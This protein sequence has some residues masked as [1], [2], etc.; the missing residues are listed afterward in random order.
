VN[1]EPASDLGCSVIGKL[2]AKWQADSDEQPTGV[3]S[4]SLGL[5]MKMLEKLV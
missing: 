4:E 2:M 3:L 5:V 1:D